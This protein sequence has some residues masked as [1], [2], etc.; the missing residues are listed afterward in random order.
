MA[1]KKILNI[2]GA[3]AFF[4]VAMGH[5]ACREIGDAYYEQEAGN[6]T[7][8]ENTSGYVWPDGKKYY[9]SGGK[10][11]LDESPDKFSLSFDEKYVSE[12]RQY[13]D[14]IDGLQYT[15]IS[16]YY[17]EPEV[18]AT[19]NIF[20]LTT[21]ESVD[22]KELKKQAGVKSV[23]P[24]YTTMGGRKCWITEQI[25][26]RFKD[27]VS[28]QEVDEMHKKFNVSIIKDHG[29]CQVLSVPVELDPL[30]V[31]NAYYES[32]LVIYSEPNFW[33]KVTGYDI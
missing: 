8:E 30:E 4:M 2:L 3:I 19:R 14:K 18:D 7:E 20:L 23:N 13:L 21:A 5:V 16:K 28:L 9:Y 15:T 17:D 24:M 33:A 10:I 22:V 27:G 12:I 26:M 31:A 32:G 6:N 29:W 11:Y 25:V 1:M